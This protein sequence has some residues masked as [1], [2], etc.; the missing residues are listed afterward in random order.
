ME[1]NGLDAATVK[2]LA[3]RGQNVKFAPR[4][5]ANA[6]AVGVI[7]GGLREA[8]ADPRYEGVGAA[9]P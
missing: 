7:P 9:T 1:A 2:Q 4:G 6:H 3:A 5:G 8:A